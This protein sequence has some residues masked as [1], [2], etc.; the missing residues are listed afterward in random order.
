MELNEQFSNYLVAAIEKMKAG[1]FEGDEAQQKQILDICSKLVLKEMESEAEKAKFTHEVEMLD[2]R[3]QQEKDMEDLK[4]R[5]AKS[6]FEREKAI[7]E[8]R[9]QHDLDLKIEQDKHDEVLKKELIEGNLEVVKR[10]GQAAIDV[11]KIQGF[12]GLGNS[13][14]GGV[15]TAVG[16]GLGAL[17]GLGATI[18][19]Q[20]LQHQEFGELLGVVNSELSGDLSIGSSTGRSL[21]TGVGKDISSSIFKI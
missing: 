19:K 15:G 5:S 16:G 18:A 8:L 4:D 21:L 3:N 17:G 7:E 14:I 9:N 11:A 6:V 12:F 20:R 1:D 2:K 13:L 10:Q